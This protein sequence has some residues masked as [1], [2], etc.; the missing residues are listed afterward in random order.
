MMT[1]PFRIGLI[2]VVIGIVA[3]VIIF[4][5]NQKVT[6][7]RTLELE[8]TYS[9]NLNLKDGGIGYYKITVPNFDGQMIFVQIEDNVGNVISD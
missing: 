7:A 5:D 2:L 1:S 8:D 4:D 3:I 6:A 9:L